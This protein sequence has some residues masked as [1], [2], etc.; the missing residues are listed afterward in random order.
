MGFSTI[1]YFIFV[2]YVCASAGLGFYFARSQRSSQDYFLGNRELPWLAVSLSVVATETSTL[3]FIG[4]PALAYGSNLMFLQITLGYLL[5]RILVALIFLPGYFS[6]NATTAYD[7]IYQRFGDNARKASSGIFMVT[8]LL[9]DGV[10]L[11]ATAIPLKILTGLSYPVSIGLICAVTILYTYFG[12]LKAVVWLDVIQFLVYL[13]GAGIA[14]LIIVDR[15]PGGWDQA[16]SL[17][18]TAGK[19][20]W[21]DFDFDFSKSYTIWSG[22][23]GGTVFG[24][25]SHGIDQLMV[26]RLLGC[27][28]LRDSQKAIVGSGVFVIVQ[29]IFFLFMGVLLFAFYQAFPEKL[30]VSRNDE[31]FPLFIANELPPGVGGLIIAAIFAAA[32]STLSSSLNA[33]G[34]STVVDWLKSTRWAQSWDAVLELKISRLSTI[35]WGGLLV[36]TAIFAGSWGNVLETGLAVASFTY[37]GLLGI[38]LLARWFKNV[39]A[40]M[41]IAAMFT[42]VAVM[43]FIWLSETAIAWP[44]FVLIG[45]SVT[46][47]GGYAHSFLKR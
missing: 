34:S 14:M 3:T 36:V 47:F 6:Q 9:A 10:R 20:E 17:A 37:G 23:I 33:L 40:T 46:I 45:A 30:S 8:R 35:F 43:F 41:A 25:A 2:V 29:F 22:I 12:G 4:I 44:W 7:F 5:A 32:M 1:D 26:Q 27:R 11:F 15:L 31:I 16:M 19:L 28:N 39:D 13:T 38:F 42:G 18:G 24:L 21:L